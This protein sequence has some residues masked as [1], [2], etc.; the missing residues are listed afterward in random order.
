MSS[1]PLVVAVTG[2]G[3]TR[4]VTLPG[5]ASITVHQAYAETT[6]CRLLERHGYDM[7]APVD[8]VSAGGEVYLSV[9]SASWVLALARGRRGIGRRE[10][11][12]HALAYER[13]LRLPS[14]APKVDIMPSL[15]A[16]LYHLSTVGLS[17]SA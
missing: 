2:S 1:E 14:A 16:D 12:D 3:P 17:P 8:F 7:T 6:V 5:L 11:F 4:I 13:A 9:P 10:L 15:L